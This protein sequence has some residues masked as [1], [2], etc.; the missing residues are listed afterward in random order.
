MKRVLLAMTIAAITLGLGA[1]RARADGAMSSG[2]GSGGGSSGGFGVGSVG[3]W[4]GAPS[5]KRRTTG[6]G[7]PQVAAKKPDADTQKANAAATTTTGI[8]PKVT[9]GAVSAVAA[10]GLAL[11]QRRGDAGEVNTVR[12]NSVGD[13]PVRLRKNAEN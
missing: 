8:L 10:R 2:G 5:E 6:V 1:G 4:T 13:S 9:T 12:R 3:G 7:A 11:G